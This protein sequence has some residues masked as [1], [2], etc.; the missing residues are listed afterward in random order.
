LTLGRSAGNQKPPPYGTQRQTFSEE[1]EKMSENLDRSSRLGGLR[2]FAIAITLL[3]IVGHVFLGFEQS[4]AQPVVAL[5]AAYS[6][7]IAIETLN[8]WANRRKPYYLEGGWR[9]WIDFLLSAH[10]TALAVAMLTYANDRLWQVVFGTAIAVCSKAV[11]RIPAG[12]GTR[13]FFNPSNF[14][15]TMTILVFPWV[16][17]SP[18]Y[19]FTEN[20]I[21]IGDWIL[22]A[23]II[24]SGS[25]LNARFTR[26]LPLIGAWLGGFALQAI[27][28]HLLLG[29][30]LTGALMPM[31]GVAFILYTFYMV[32]DPATTPSS[33]QSQVAFGFGVAF[34]YS[35]LMLGHIVF[36]LFFALTIVCAIRGVG[37]YALTFISLR[38]RTKIA[39][40]T[41]I[42]VMEA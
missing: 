17:V 16:G 36:G 22:P 42:E 20:L 7:E 23:F 33:T 25:F 31:T 1:D 12:K 32:T 41:P 27:L 9:N 24:L 19:H 26:R 8:A 11:F 10:I 38:K 6:L 4:L 39:S 28:R 18:P 30:S 40:Q 21:G 29:A 37:I 14:G 34:V 15:I 5:L 35:L 2:R 3:N 13:H